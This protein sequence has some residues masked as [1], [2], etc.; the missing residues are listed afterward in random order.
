MYADTILIFCSLPERISFWISV[1]WG[2]SDRAKTAQLLKVLHSHIY[3]CIYMYSLIY[4][5]PS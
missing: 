1:F 3:I 4:V 5:F 2:R